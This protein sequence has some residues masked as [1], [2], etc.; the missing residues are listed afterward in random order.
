MI[1]STYLSDCICCLYNQHLALFD[2]RKV[3]LGSDETAFSC[4]RLRFVKFTVEALYDGFPSGVLL[5]ASAGSGV[6][7]LVFKGVWTQL[8]DILNISFADQVLVSLSCEI[9][10][11]V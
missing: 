3:R 2:D 8:V 7:A 4:T 6:V 10:D 1:S 9:S 5:A 11:A